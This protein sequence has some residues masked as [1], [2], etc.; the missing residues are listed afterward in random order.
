MEIYLDLVMVLNF[1]VDFFL[2]MGTN[3]F[4]GYPPSLKRVIPAAVLGGVYGGLC[5]MPGLYFLGNL[6][7]RVVFLMLI[8][9]IAFG[10]NRS[11]LQ[12]TCT[13]VLL[14]M[15]LGGIAVGMS[16]GGFGA[17]IMAAGGVSAL[18]FIIYR[19][20]TAE[21]RCVD[22][23]IRHGSRRVS[24][25]A[26]CDTGNQLRDPLTGQQVL[27]VGADIAKK[28]LDLEPEQLDKPIDTV[29]RAGISGLRIIPYKAVGQSGGMLLA[30]R[31]DEVRID[32][33][34]GSTLVAFAP[35]VLG[36]GCG[37][38]GLTGGQG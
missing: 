15:A 22:A 9:S 24:F 33:W 35:N 11:A 2:L 4:S 26:L 21:G 13:F 18:C 34:K 16:R 36:H 37:Y 32:K 19:Y 6:L 8:A 17:L 10:V 31:C 12:R 29:T 30:L 25:V 3:R 7:W 28:L 5:L 27:V 1:L 23:E 20:K 38:Q 14:S